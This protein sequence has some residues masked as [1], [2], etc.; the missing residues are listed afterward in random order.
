[1]ELKQER[2]GIPTPPDE[3]GGGVGVGR[4]LP[5]LG[6]FAMV[7]EHIINHHERQRQQQQQQQQQQQGQQQPMQRE[8]TRSTEEAARGEGINFLW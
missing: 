2:E 8:R 4:S 7:H 1:M 6:P 3:R 5:S